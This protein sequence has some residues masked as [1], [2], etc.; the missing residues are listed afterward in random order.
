MV[1]SDVVHGIDIG[2]SEMGRC[3]S[4]PG[5]IDVDADVERSG[6]QGSVESPAGDMAGGGDIHAAAGEGNS[7]GRRDDGN[8]AAQK[9]Q[10]VSD[11]V[12]A[13]DGDH[14]RS[15]CKLGQAD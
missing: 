3:G 4:S 11:R 10:G 2:T 5:A 9:G 15:G 8:A 7:L 12:D 13:E 14:V 1:A 6:G